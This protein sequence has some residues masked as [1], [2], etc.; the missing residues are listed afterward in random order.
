MAGLNRATLESTFNRLVFEH[1][2]AWVNSLNPEHPGYNPVLRLSDRN[3]R[4]KHGD[5]HADMEARIKIICSAML[6]VIAENNRAI[7]EGMGD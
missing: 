1:N 2:T 7:S 4:A 6:D 5:T 3:E